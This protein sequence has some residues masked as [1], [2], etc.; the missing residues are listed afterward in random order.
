MFTFV[1]PF[2][3]TFYLTFNLSSLPLPFF[4][5]TTIVSNTLLRQHILKKGS[6]LDKWTSLGCEGFKVLARRVY[7][8]LS[9][10]ELDFPK[11]LASREVDDPDLL[12]QYLYRDDALRL[13]NAIGKYCFSII[14]L[15]YKTNDDIAGDPE[16]QVKI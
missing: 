14:T 15:F 12:P 8:K 9:F 4:S 1:L 7:K 11:E 10:T 5:R 3:F 2:R 6:G 13:W 16:L